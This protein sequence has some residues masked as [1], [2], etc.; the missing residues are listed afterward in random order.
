[1]NQFGTTK[2]TIPGTTFEWK[3]NP[4]ASRIILDER[5][6][7]EFRLR[8]LVKFMSD[9]AVGISVALDED[10]RVFS[11]EEARREAARMWDNES[12]SDAEVR[13]N[14]I[15]RYNVESYLSALQ[16][17][18]CGD[19][20]HVPCS[21]IKCWAEEIAGTDTI[22]GLRGGYSVANAFKKAVTLQQVID[23]IESRSYQPDGTWKDNHIERWKVCDRDCLQWLKRYQEL[24]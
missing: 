11:V 15:E 7:E 14:L 24:L 9:G 21:C 10:T 1:M 18:H 23:S 2:D 13:S 5:G 12:K 20:I 22:A 8:A 4:L 3:E 6:K 19:C 16:E 17:E